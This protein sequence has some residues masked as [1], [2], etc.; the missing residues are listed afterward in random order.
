MTRRL[1]QARSR[2]P[3]G[4]WAHRVTR[5]ASKWMRMASLALHAII[6]DGVHKKKM[7][8]SLFDSI[9]DNGNVALD[10]EQRRLRA[11]PSAYRVKIVVSIHD[12]REDDGDVHLVKHVNSAE[13]IGSQCEIRNLVNHVA[14]LKDQIDKARAHYVTW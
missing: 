11:Q 14:L 4:A 2:R 9:I 7:K 5:S 3:A 8:R 6:V 1:R 13:L 10:L 12:D